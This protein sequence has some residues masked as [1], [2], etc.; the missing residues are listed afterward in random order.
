M[1]ITRKYPSTVIVSLLGLLATMLFGAWWAISFVSAY[2]KYH[3]NSYEPN[4]ACD[5]AG[6]HC[7]AAALVLVL[8]FFGKSLCYFS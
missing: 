2:I 4:P 5:L 6:G 8:I 7:S 1:Q 3:P